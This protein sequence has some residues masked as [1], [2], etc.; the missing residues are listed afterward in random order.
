MAIAK[1]DILEAVGSMSVLELNELV[2][3]FERSLAC[4]LL[5]SQW[6]ARQRVAVQPQRLK[7]K[8]NSR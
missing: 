6:Q 4:R 2:K 3:A 7:S 8:P 5:L 1:E